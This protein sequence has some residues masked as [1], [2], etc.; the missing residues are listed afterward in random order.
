MKFLFLVRNWNDLSGNLLSYC[1]IGTPNFGKIL[2]PFFNKT[3]V[4]KF[5]AKIKIC[6]KQYSNGGYRG[7]SNLR[8]DFISI[9]S[10]KS[11]KT[12][13]NIE[14]IKRIKRIKRINVGIKV[15]IAWHLTFLCFFYSSY[16]Y[17]IF[18]SKNL[19]FSY[20]LLYYTTE[21]SGI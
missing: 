20:N 21:S 9:K 16:A 19:K 18:S 1:T 17:K 13:K 3:S 2:S 4:I 7:I 6:D 12:I 11:I 10:I 5:L 8:K 14:R 15:K